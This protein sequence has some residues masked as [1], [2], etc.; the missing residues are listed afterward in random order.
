MTETIAP[1]YATREEWL[2]AALEELRPMF[3]AEGHTLSDRIRIA[4]GFPSTATRSGAIGECHASVASA[5]QH[6]ELLI[7]PTVDDA[8]KVFEVLV[9]ELC[10]TL[11]GC[12]NHGITFQ[13]AAHAMH[14]APG[15]SKGWKAT[16]QGPTFDQAYRQIID[17]LGVYPHAALRL[18]DR[19]KQGTRLLKAVCPSCGYTLRLTRLWAD[20][21]LP[22]CSLD[23]STFNLA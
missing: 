4:C 17:S 19:K 13:S 10:H 5:D 6:Y 18:A 15:A 8:S 23:G 14:L 9:H 7:S 16:V 22:T 20:K 2:V 3:A 11:P 1:L 21:G 12:L